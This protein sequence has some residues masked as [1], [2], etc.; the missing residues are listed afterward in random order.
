MDGAAVADLDFE[1]PVLRVLGASGRGKV[2][3]M[4]LLFWPA[5]LPRSI[6]NPVHEAAGAADIDMGARRDRTQSLMQHQLLLGRA[7]VQVKTHM[8]GHRF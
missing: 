8:Q 3:A 7:I 6:Q 4:Q 5:G 1:L 2:L